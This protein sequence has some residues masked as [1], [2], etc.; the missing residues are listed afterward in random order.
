M[1]VK[2]L[3]KKL[4]VQMDDYV[5]DNKNRQLLAFLSLLTICEVFEEV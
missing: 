3:P 5:K 2:S 1:G 4:L